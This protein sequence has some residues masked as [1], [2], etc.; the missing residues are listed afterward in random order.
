MFHNSGNEGLRRRFNLSEAF[1]FKDYTDS[2]LR[3]ILKHMVIKDQLYIAPETLDLAIKEISKK[4]VLEGFGNAGEAEMI[5]GHAKLKMA[6]RRSKGLVS[7]E[8]I[9]ML[10]D[11]D[12]CPA[13]A[14]TAD[15][16][17]EAFADV[18]NIEHISQLIDDLEALV[19]QA[20]SD[21]E[22]AASITSRMH[23]IFT[24][25]VRVREMA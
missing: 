18:E 8:A 24:V 16:A 12:F 7:I 19:M 1:E 3:D 9:N 4:R 23:L 25:R 6:A 21:D 20:K 22:D 10:L 13:E 15:K 2:E 5:L 17:R 11:S 14:S